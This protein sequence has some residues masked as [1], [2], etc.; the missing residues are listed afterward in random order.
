M[1]DTIK[2]LVYTIPELAKKLKISVSTAY[3]L[4]RAKDFPIIKIGRRKLIPARELEMWISEH[5]N[6]I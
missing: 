1:K 3:V 5:C 2:P 6:G 4:S